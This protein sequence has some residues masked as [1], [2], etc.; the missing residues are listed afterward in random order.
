MDDEYEVVDLS[1]IRKQSYPEYYNTLDTLSDSLDGSAEYN[2]N[3]AGHLPVGDTFRGYKT[4][5]KEL[6]VGADRGDSLLKERRQ[7]IR[8]LS[9]LDICSTVSYMKTLAI[10]KKDPTFMHTLNLPIKDLH[11]KTYHKAFPPSVEIRVTV[12]HLK[13]VPGAIV[14]YGNHVRNG[15]PY[16][17]HL[18]KGDPTVESNWYNPGGHYNSCGRIEMMGLESATR[19][20][21]RMRTDGPDG[22]G[23]WSVP[24]SIV[25]L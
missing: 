18:C 7:S 8:N 16:L 9:D 12:K 5:M 22:P 23:Q 10:H 15:G 14:I 20:W 25:V 17:V 1:Q 4:T 19:Y 3:R 13:K 24:V 21:V 11:A 2:A 6:G